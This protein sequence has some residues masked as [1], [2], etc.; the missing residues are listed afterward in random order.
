MAKLSA[1]L[2]VAVPRALVDKLGLQPGD[3]VE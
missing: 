2:E 1:K 3:E